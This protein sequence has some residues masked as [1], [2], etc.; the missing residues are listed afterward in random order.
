M[1]KTK[2]PCHVGCFFKH[3]KQ[4]ALTGLN[5]NF[6]TLNR[7]GDGVHHKESVE[8]DQLRGQLQK[9]CCQG[10]ERSIVSCGCCSKNFLFPSTERY[11]HL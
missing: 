2:I 4:N 7:H 6:K 9:I 10:Y 11:A 5:N 3:N 1:K 8:A